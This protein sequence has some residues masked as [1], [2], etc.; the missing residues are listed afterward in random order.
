MK[1]YTRIN[2]LL[3]G[4]VGVVDTVKLDKAAQL[5]GGRLGCTTKEIFIFLDREGI[6]INKFYRD[7]QRMGY[8]WTGEDW[9]KMAPL[10]SWYQ[11]LKKQMG[12]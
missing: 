7:I 8:V 9:L 4:G 10:P 6:S 3:L 1:W 11:R 2:I 12:A 5:I